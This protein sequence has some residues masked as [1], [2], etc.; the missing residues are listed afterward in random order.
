MILDINN[1]IGKNSLKCLFILTQ[2]IIILIA[3]I[4]FIFRDMGNFIHIKC[5]L[6]LKM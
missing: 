1:K 2:E 5:C 6:F 3:W 4:L